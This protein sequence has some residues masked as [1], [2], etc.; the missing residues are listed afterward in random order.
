M[1]LRLK[2]TCME[3]NVRLAGEAGQGI[4]VAAELLGKALTRSGL[5]AYSYNDAESRIRGGLNFNHIRCCTKP[6]QGV[7]EGIDLLVALSRPALDTFVPMLSE[8]GGV[9]CRGEWR[10]PSAAPFFLERIAEDAGNPKVA[11]TAGVAAVCRTVGIEREVVAG[12]VREKFSG[13]VQEIN[14]KAV[15]M[16]YD[17]AAEWDKASGD[18]ALKP[19]GESAGR[20]WC[21]GVQAVALGAIAGGVR[22]MTAYPMS[23]ATGVMVNLAGWADRAGLVVVQAEDEIAAVNMV[24][25]AS[26][27]GARA[28]TA[29]SG[30]GFSLMCEG[31]S[32]IGMIEAPAVFVLAQRPGPATGLP[33]RQAQGDLH[34]AINAGHGFFPRI[35]LA[36]RNV[37]D[38]FAVTARAF[39]LA[40]RYQVPVIVLTDQLLHDSQVTLDP[41]DVSGLPSER[42]FLSPEE[43]ENMKDYQRFARTETGISP[44]AAPGVS[45]HTVIVDSD[46]HDENGHLIESAA[47]VRRMS[48]KR[49]KKSRS[50]TGATEPPELDGE[51]GN[52]PLVLTWG[53]T[54]ETAREAV[55][56]VK[57]D[58]VSISHVNLRWL[59]PPPE[60]DLSRIVSEAP[61]VI[62]VENNVD[63]QMARY[64]RNH[65]G[66]KPDTIVNRLDGRPLEVDDLVE[67][68]GEEVV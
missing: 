60:D 40:E 23:P 55:E 57:K 28:M 42:H 63:G 25:G 49:L 68:I 47:I 31:V 35:I 5:W 38:C 48:E 21:A 10:H 4:Q 56:R 65:T 17:A 44:L 53:S 1:L 20:L 64:L 22:F 7:V 62:V 67:R 59:W 34:M 3:T 18:M 30:G 6:H 66:R 2:G 19:E 11:G 14:L 52:G 12:L 13:S 58:S 39:D 41:F 37:R 54:F 50:V 27:A 33:T 43:L 46:E 29:T 9:I 32:L 15:N 26:Y 8:Q 61:K 51:G 36:P 24:A 45:R 16:G